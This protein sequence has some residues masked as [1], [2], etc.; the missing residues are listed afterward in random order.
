ML[1][2]DVYK[3][4]ASLGRIVK[5]PREPDE[6]PVL[7]LYCVCFRYDTEWPSRIR[8]AQQDSAFK[9]TYIEAKYINIWLR[10]DPKH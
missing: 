6:P 8:V 4:R 1:G 10:Y 2:V 5:D 7:V 9:M 3:R